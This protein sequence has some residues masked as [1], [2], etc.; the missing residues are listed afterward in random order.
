MFSSTA[1][2][3]R[4]A[5]PIDV[6]ALELLARLDSRPRPTGRILIG[7]VDGHA[8]AAIAVDSGHVVAD[9]FVPTE[10]LVAHLRLR[11][12]SIRAHERMPSVRD[13]ILAGLRN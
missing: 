2:N 11:A 12:A 6:P 5:A 9:P 8:A 1:F 7:E 4:P 10:L 13:R 3:I